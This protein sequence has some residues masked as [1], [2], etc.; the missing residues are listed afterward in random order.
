MSIDRNINLEQEVW[1]V[2]PNLKASQIKLKDFFLKH[3]DN[4]KIP[5][6]FQTEKEAEQVISEH[7]QSVFTKED[8]FELFKNDALKNLERFEKGFK[9]AD[10]FESLRA[11]L[12]TDKDVALAAVSRYGLVLKDVG[13]DLQDDRDVVIAAVNTHGEA[14][15]YASDR[16][17]ADREIVLAAVSRSGHGLE[18]A[19]EKF[20]LD[21]EIAKIAIETTSY[22]IEHVA[23]PLRSEL[24]QENELER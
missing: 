7:Y 3:A 18:W 15:E 21:K 10:F 13:D 4:E 8:V 9:A 24:E 2:N 6:Y 14:L 16:F 17:K 23:E 19:N 11:E 5:R 22:A 12:R 1:V 20:K